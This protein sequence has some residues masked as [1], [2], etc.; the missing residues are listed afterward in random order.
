MSLGGEKEGNGGRE[1][2][3]EDRERRRLLRC[4]TFSLNSNALFSPLLILV[5]CLL[6]VFSSVLYEKW[7]KKRKKDLGDRWRKDEQEDDKMV[8]FSILFPLLLAHE[9]G[10]KWLGYMKWR[11]YNA[12]PLHTQV[13][14][15]RSAHSLWRFCLYETCQGQW[16]QK[17]KIYSPTACM[18]V[19]IYKL[20]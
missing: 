1:G 20:H 11:A 5:Q 2:R 13:T 17:S 19:Q 8:S 10:L 7:K 3:E 4:F 18:K 16:I 12:K 9:L 15:L 6:E 14:L